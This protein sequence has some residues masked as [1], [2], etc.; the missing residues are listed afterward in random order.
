MSEKTDIIPSSG[1]VFA[2]LDLPQPDELLAKADL[3]LQIKSIAKHRHLS[4]AQTAQLLGTTQPKVSELFAGK[5]AGFSMERLIKYLMALNRDVTLVVAP[6]TRSSERATLRV[7]KS[8]SGVK[9]AGSRSAK[10]APVPFDRDE[11]SDGQQA[12]EA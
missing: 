12:L 1:N 8:S 7:L 6:K 9:G 5:L 3:A 11:S 10:R 2:D 4:Q